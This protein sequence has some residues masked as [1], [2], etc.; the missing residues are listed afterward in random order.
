MPTEASYEARPVVAAIHLD[1]DE[2]VR[3]ARIGHAVVE[4]GNA[5][6]PEESAES[7]EA[8]RPRKL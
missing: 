6:P 5:A 2:D 8:S 3:V 4:L 1:T 7:L